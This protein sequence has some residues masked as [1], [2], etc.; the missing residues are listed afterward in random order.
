MLKNYSNENFGNIIKSKPRNSYMYLLKCIVSVTKIKS[1]Q[2]KVYLR[3][4]ISSA[5]IT[6][7]I[8]PYSFTISF[9]YV[10]VSLWL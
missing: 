1:H 9:D 3:A 8:Q 10:F 2:L 7:L 4:S 6:I 5:V